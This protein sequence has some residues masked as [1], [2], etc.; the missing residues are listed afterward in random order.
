[1]RPAIEKSDHRFS[2]LLRAR[3]QGPCYGAAE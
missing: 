3:C 1:V 2:R